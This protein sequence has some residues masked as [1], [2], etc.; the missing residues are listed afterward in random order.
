MRACK[1]EVVG[2]GSSRPTKKCSP[3][4]GGNAYRLER[5][6]YR[7]HQLCEV[8]VS[9]YKRNQLTML[10]RDGLFSERR[11]NYVSSYSFMSA[12]AKL[13]TSQKA[14]PL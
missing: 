1:V 11:Q 6:Y 10:L 2:G 13:R 8:S 3:A 7:I 9:Q 14:E 12:S 5:R 4:V